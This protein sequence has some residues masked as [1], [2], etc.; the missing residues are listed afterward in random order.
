MKIVVFLLATSLISFCSYAEATSL[1]P[2]SLK[3][4]VVDKASN[5]L[6]IEEAKHSFSEGKLKEALNQFKVAYSKDS[7]SISAAYWVAMCYYR[8]NNYTQALQYM[9]K[10][11]SLGQ[12][13]DGEQYALLAACFHS[14][15]ML[16]SAFVNYSKSLD[17]LSKQRAVELEIWNKMEECKFAKEQFRT[18]K[19]NARKLLS[20]EINTEFNEYAPILVDSGRVLYFA[21]RRSSTTGGMRNPDDEQY[22]ED[23]YTAKWNSTYKMWD[24][25]TNQLGKIN[26]DGFEALTYISPDGT[27]G[28]LTLNTT[29]LDIAETT[30]SSDI[31]EV[32]M[33]NGVWQRPKVIMNSSINTSYYD[34]SATMTA[35]G[36]TMYFVSDRNGEKSST[37]IYMV[38]R[39]GKKWGEAIALPVNV[40]SPGRETTPYITP[41]GKYLFFSSDGHKGMGGYDVYVTQFYGTSW[42]KPINLGSS[43]NTV[44]DDTHFQYY[45][46]LKRVVMAGITLDENQCNYNLYEIDLS[47]ASLPIKLD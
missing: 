15:E 17:K 34:G 39:K 23:I 25:V 19:P 9:V 16:D 21:A 35:D 40:N 32:E 18:Q 10:V 20:G 38:K 28:L 14:N 30:E 27:K 5:T 31:C 11:R 8:L 46:D 29:A 4:S 6:L 2:D 44:N 47:K 43:I 36:N 1:P 33:K 37:D 12:E 13:L 3:V 7:R 45:P 26:G 24:S 22:F 41:D 42:S